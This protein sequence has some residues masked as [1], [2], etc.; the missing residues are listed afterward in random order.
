[1]YKSWNI[2]IRMNFNLPRESHRFFLQPVS[3]QPH[4]KIQLVKRFIKFYKTISSCNKPHLKYL[5]NIQECDRRS[6]FGR[7][8]LNICSDANVDTLFNVSL[9]DIHYVPVPEAEEWKIPLL[10]EL[11]EIRSG[12]PQ[13]NLS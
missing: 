8:V 7:N 3:Q 13:S 1:M 6:I 4:L 11:I 12:R 2:M 5:M 10:Q 9:S